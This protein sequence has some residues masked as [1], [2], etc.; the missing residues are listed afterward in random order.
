MPV[1][2]DVKAGKKHG[3]KFRKILEENL[4]HSGLNASSVSVRLNPYRCFE[5]C[6]NG[7][8]R[9]KVKGVPILYQLTLCVI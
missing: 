6:C 2:R 3:A 8:K 7:I 4:F 5:V 1:K 9:D